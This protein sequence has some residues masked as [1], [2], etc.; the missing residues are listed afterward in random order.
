[1]ANKIGHAI[2]RARREQK[3]SQGDLARKAGVPRVSIQR[4]EAGSTVPAVDRVNKIAQALG[5]TVDCLIADTGKG[6]S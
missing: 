1:M 6:E 4:Y 5:T 2:R 3:L